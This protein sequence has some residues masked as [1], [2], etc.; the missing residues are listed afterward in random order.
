[1]ELKEYLA[2]FRKQANFLGGII[3]LFLLGGTVFKL[4][5]PVRYHSQVTLNVTRQGIERTAAY[6]FD[7]FYRLQADEKFADTVVR[8]LATD[9]MKLNIQNEATIDASNFL[10]LSGKRLS[11]QI[12]AVDIVAAEAETAEKLS[13]SVAKV[14]NRE[15]E[16]LNQFQKEESW[17]LVVAD[18]PVTGI[19]AWQWHKIIFV[20]LS[21]GLLVGFWAGLIR[22]YLS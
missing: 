11:S 4:F 6:R 18:D 19:V 21:F 8:W 1:M 12:V 2:I 9:R 5:Q 13:F 14:V 7:D 17:F 15:A 3:L 22:H 10:S 16:K 20:S